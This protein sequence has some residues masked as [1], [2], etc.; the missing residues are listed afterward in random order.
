MSGMDLSLLERARN[1]LKLNAAESGA[2]ELIRELLDLIEECG[3]QLSEYEAR[4]TIGL[5]RERALIL[6]NSDLKRL[7]RHWREE[8]G[9]LHAKIAKL[10]ADLASWEITARLLEQS[11]QEAERLPPTNIKQ[12]C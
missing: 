3:Y 6:E 12:N 7:A 11:E 4:E 8:C 2:D 9:K 1:Y 5:G 10:Q